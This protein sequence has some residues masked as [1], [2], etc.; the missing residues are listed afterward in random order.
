MFPQNEDREFARLAQHE[1]RITPGVQ[2]T[3]APGFFSQRQQGGAGPDAGE[4]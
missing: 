1:T 2:P 3:L 4:H